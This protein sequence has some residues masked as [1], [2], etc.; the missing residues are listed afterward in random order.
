MEMDLIEYNKK[1]VFTCI[2]VF[3]R[4]A[5]AKMLRNKEKGTVLSAMKKVFK[6]VKALNHNSWPKAVLSD[7]GSEFKNDKMSAWLEKK[8]IKQIFGIPGSPTGQAFIERFNG[9]LKQLMNKTTLNS[10]EVLNKTILRN[11]LNA[12]NNQTH[13]TTSVTPTEGLQASNKEVIMKSFKDLE[14]I[15]QPK[16]DLKVGDKVRL[17]VEKSKIDK[18]AIKWTEEIFTVSKVTR[19]NNPLLPIKYKIKGNDGEELKGYIP[20][21]HL[22]KI[23]KTEGELAVFYEVNRILKKRKLRGKVQYLVSWKGYT[24][25]EATWQDGKL[26][27]EQV[28]DKVVAFEEKQKKR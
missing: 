11:V 17:A 23:D 1:F 2:D 21:E 27:N 18:S 20:R 7:N 24:Q 3:S 6:E 25:D 5:Y 15:G 8:G 4:H 22:Q 26:L 14:P 13:D 19:N 12:Y 28:P 9:T 10:G 16:D